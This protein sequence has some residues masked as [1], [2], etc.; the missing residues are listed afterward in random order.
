MSASLYRVDPS[1]HFLTAA[2]TSAPLDSLGD[3]ARHFLD[4][5]WTLLRDALTRRRGDEARAAEQREDLV[6]RHL[7]DSMPSLLSAMTRC[8]CGSRAGEASGP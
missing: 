1:N 2:D 3:E 8:G 6:T 4:T 7:L 5:S